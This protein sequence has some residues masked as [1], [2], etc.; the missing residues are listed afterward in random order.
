MTSNLRWAMKPLRTTLNVSDLVR[1][2]LIVVAVLVSTRPL[3]GQTPNLGASISAYRVQPGD[4]LIFELWAGE[5]DPILGKFPVEPSGDAYLPKLGRVKAAG[6]TVEELRQSL[7]QAYGAAYENPVVVIRPVFP[8]AIMGGVRTPSIQQI[9][10]GQSVFDAVTAAG[11][12][13]DTA[14]TDQIQLLR[15]GKTFTVNG[16]SELALMP[17][18]SGDRVMVPRRSRLRTSDV[19]GLVQTLA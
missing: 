9:Q 12:F 1:W 18:H 11:G 17:L 4:I 6:F 7:R 2:T 16:L 8:I 14:K 13:L 3:E 5:A 15:E 19:Y 10:P